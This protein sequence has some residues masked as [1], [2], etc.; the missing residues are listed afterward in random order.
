[1]VMLVQ[2]VW[3]LCVAA[4]LVNGSGRAPMAAAP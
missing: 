4:L 3:N 2:I 1:M